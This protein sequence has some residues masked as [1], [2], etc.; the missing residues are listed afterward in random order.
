MQ[1]SI[2]DVLAH[3]EVIVVGNGAPEFREAL[4]R[5]R[6]GV[7]VIDFVRVADRKSVAGEYDGICW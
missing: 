7:E 1:T 6:P 4:K 3:A 5:V 2:D